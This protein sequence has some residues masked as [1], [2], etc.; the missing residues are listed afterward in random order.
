MMLAIE[1]TDDI[2]ACHAIRRVVFI[3]EQG[4][5]EVEE[6]DNLDDGALH[7]LAR[8]GDA[9]VGTARVILVGDTVKIGRVCV[10]KEHRGKGFGA[11]IIT[12]ILDQF[13]GHSAVMRAKL[14]AQTHAI[15]FY[16]RL[17]FEAFGPIYLDAGIEHRDMVCVL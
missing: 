5:S 16:R 8:I 6:L 3:E 13:S 11:Q 7:F 4:V 14:G 2:G 10:L 9:N 1:E 17:G 12:Q 15:E